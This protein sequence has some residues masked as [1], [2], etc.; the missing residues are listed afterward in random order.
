MLTTPITT[1]HFHS[2]V[3]SLLSS[4]LSNIQAVSRDGPGTL[5]T[6]E[7]VRPFVVPQLG[8]ADTSLT[9]NEAMSQLM[10]VTSSW[11]DLCSPDPLIAD[12]SRQVF[13][14]EVAYAAF[15]GI[16]YLFVPGPK[17]HHNGMHSEGVIYYAR[18][19][20]DAINLGPY[21]QFHIWLNMVDNQDLESDEMGDLAPFAREEF[22]YNN[23]MEPP[24]I[25]LFG[26][27][28][29]WDAIRRTC[30]YHSRLFVGKTD[31]PNHFTIHSCLVLRRFPSSPATK[32]PTANECAI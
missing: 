23:G 24:K 12:I 6:T 28:D 30:K 9:P 18:A 32:K 17:L 11:I 10:G 7:N 16:G 13:M 3:L 20:Q 14:L 5:M 27:W 22:F 25:D 1:P 15:Y 8:P 4:H 19:I 2:R 21:I 29:A 31:L 26:T